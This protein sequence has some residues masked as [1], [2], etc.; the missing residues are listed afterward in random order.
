[1]KI[2]TT[3]KMLALAAALTMFAGSAA[4]AQVTAQEKKSEQQRVGLGKVFGK[5]AK[6]KQSAQKSK[7]D[8]KP[9]ASEK[10]NASNE[11][12]LEPDETSAM[13]SDVPAD[14]QANRHESISEEQALIEPYY[15]NFFATYRLGPED[16][17]SV[18]V[19]GQ[20]RYS[21]D[22]IVVPPNGK[23]SMPLLPEGIFVVGKT[24]DQVAEQIRKRYDEYV[25]DPKVDVSLDKANS[26]RYMVIGDVAQP[27]VKPM[28]RRMTVF[29]ALSEA[30][31]VLNTGDKKKI[32]VLRRQA[33]GQ[34][35][36][37]PVNIS[38]IEKGR[39]AD[40]FYL[41]SGDQIVVPGNKFKTLKAIT[42]MLPVL[43]FARIF[44][45]GF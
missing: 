40:T 26:Y 11:E 5:D 13:P 33:S 42:D 43:S 22:G 41:V 10:P 35:T 17:I 28:S 1:M 44:A 14:V 15:N 2:N 37:F 6:S 45:G 24:V 8:G 4:F 20:P 3:L 27:G 32:Y 18:T 23:I 25:I 19:F 31:G 34:L 36:P 21:R 16:V 9:S 29:E 30:G 38:A 7:T 39:M 12:R